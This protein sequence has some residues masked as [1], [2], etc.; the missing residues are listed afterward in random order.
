MNLTILSFFASSYRRSPFIAGTKLSSISFQNSELTRFS[1]SAFFNVKNLNINQVKFTYFQ[2]SPI[3]IDHEE[4]NSPI[5]MIFYQH[6]LYILYNES[7][8]IKRTLFLQC[9]SQN[10]GGGIHYVNKNGMITITNSFFQNCIS[11]MQGGGIFCKCSETT[12]HSVIFT[13]CNSVS[14]QAGYFET[15]VYSE[16][17]LILAYNC[18]LSSEVTYMGPVIDI[19]NDYDEF[20][21]PS[22]YDS[23]NFSHNTIRKD[24]LTSLLSVKC[25]GNGFDYMSNIYMSLF[26]FFENVCP[27]EIECNGKDGMV[28]YIDH[29][30]MIQNHLSRAVFIV[31]GENYIFASEC[32]IG[33]DYD[34]FYY[35]KQTPNPTE[36]P[37][38]TLIPPTAPNFTFQSARRIDESENEAEQYEYVYNRA[39][40][41]FEK[42]FYVPEKFKENKNNRKSEN[43]L[44]K[45]NCK[46]N[47][48]KKIFN[49]YL[50]SHHRV[51][52][53]ESQE[54][55]LALFPDSM[56]SIFFDGCEIDYP[57]IEFVDCED[58]CYVSDFETFPIEEHTLLD[59][60]LQIDMETSESSESYALKFPTNVA[61]LVIICIIIVATIVLYA[62]VMTVVCAR[63]RIR[64]E[65]YF[66]DNNN[67]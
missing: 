57:E 15:S 43:Y 5:D 30:N 35:P 42:V 7:I 46:S 32:F 24:H 8:S 31:K 21:Y 48:R 37:W 3:I 44:M 16:I 2:S 27:S 66:D 60:E 59:I 6:P 63:L 9:K 26:T 54:I 39:K 29:F 14:S 52:N 4:E 38:P 22:F 62:M 18:F 28:M 55:V 23:F 67:A 64:N 49:R 19:T 36:S 45:K 56:G 40:A 1:S 47:D 12:V 33:H 34:V 51:F 65:N 58:Q 41:R 20:L 25:L 17:Y 10:S 13:L 53:R 50:N 61:N 11:Y